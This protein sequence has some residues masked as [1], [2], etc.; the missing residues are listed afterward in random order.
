MVEIQKEN[1]EEWKKTLRSEIITALTGNPLEKERAC[2]EVGYY[3]QC[4]APASLYKYYRD[5]S[6]NF[7]AMRDNKM[8]YSVPCNFNDV[9][10]CDI[11]IDEKE[12]FNSALQMVPDKRGVRPGSPMWRQLKQTISKEIEPL[13]YTFEYM[14]MTMGISCL[15]E[16]CDSLLMWAHY[17]NNHSGVCVE[18]ELLEINQQLGFSPVPVI[19]SDERARFCSIN[20]DTIEAD[21]T[22]VLIE[23]LTSKS[24]EWSYEKEWRIIQDNVACGDKWD[25]E[26]NGA[27]LDMIRP[28]S[29]ILG[30][31]AKPE[32]EKTVR[33]YCENSKINLYKMKKDESLYRLKKIPILQ[34]DD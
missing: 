11:S 5:T 8:W 1:N 6:L 23:S 22:S 14:K 29:V 28:S 25:I 16:L 3:Y 20:Q 18:Y 33:E 27:L 31:E 10:D 13:R 2:A 12:I 4:Y 15:S 21:S 34:F 30:C 32:F 17:A 19:Y 26:R 7:E 9:F 24:P